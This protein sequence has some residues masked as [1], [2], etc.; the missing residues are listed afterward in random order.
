MEA[1]IEFLNEEN[2][3]IRQDEWD[4][5]RLEIK[6]QIRDAIQE[7]IAPPPSPTKLQQFAEWLKKWGGI[8]ALWTIPLALLAIAIG[9]IYVAVARVDRQAHFEEKTTNTLN[10]I[11]AHL[12]KIDTAL[13]TSRIERAASNPTDKSSAI[14]A[15]IALEEARKGSIQLSPD[16]IQKTGSAFINVADR[17]PS[18]WGAALDFVQYKTY[19]NSVSVTIPKTSGNKPFYTA[20]HY[21]SPIGMKGPEI[22]NAGIV[23]ISSSAHFDYIGQTFNS[24][25]TKG[26]GAIFAKGGGI[27]LDN[28]DIEST[29]FDGV[30]IVYGGGKLILKNVYFVNCTFEMPEKANPRNLAAA[31]LD[32]SPSTS[33]SGE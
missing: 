2:V 7:A 6:Y 22:T 3:A 15:K 18:A 5:I 21:T 26:T 20:L 16:F 13:S 25:L 30:H 24:S 12:K 10:D 28:M 9:A 23:P 8:T 32:T 17:N 31:I 19:A 27:V 4:R 11:D 14:E 33:F 29:V 1:A